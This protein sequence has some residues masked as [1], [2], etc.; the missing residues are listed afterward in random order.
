[1]SSEQK[2]LEGFDG[3]SSPETETREVRIGNMGDVVTGGTPSTK[4]EDNYGGDFPFMRVSDFNN[5]PFIQETGKKLTKKGR[6]EKKNKEIPEGA[7]MVSC[8]GTLGKTAFATEN[9]LTNQQV[10][11][12]VPAEDFDNWYVYYK[13]T[14]NR[15]LLQ[16]YAGGSAQPI[17][18]KSRF[19]DIE[20][21]VQPYESQKKIGEI[22]SRFDKKIRINNRINKI[23]EKMAQTVFKAWFVDFEQSESP[24]IIDSREGSKDFEYKPL[25]EIASFQNGKAW[26]DYTGEDNGLP[27]LKI[28]ELRDGI[29][30]NT[31][32][33]DRG[34]V[35]D[36]LIVS[37]GDI[38]FS[39]SATLLIDIWT[40]RDMFL[41]QHLFKVRSENYPKWFYYHW[42]KEHIQHFRHIA[43]SK[44]TT[45]GHIKRRDLDEAMCSVPERI[46]F[47]S[48]LGN[49]LDA[50]KILAEEN[51]KLES[52]RDT[53]LPKLMSGE[54]RV[55]T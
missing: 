9:C 22:L 10:N 1:M 17:L 33:V 7:V 11:S 20:L 36:F 25:S 34:K 41:N 32:Y 21:E 55:N 46:K 40:G 3:D 49:F 45:M 19:T 50:I 39:W 30:E 37:S 52:I 24:K 16:K 18:S 13:L 2:S 29:S 28:R 43:E 42:T 48:F 15:N 51:T 44:K 26:K 38:I 5:T 23:L 31:D 27:V 12:I 8:I 53:L 14:S 54:I 47:G 4:D 35:P 6:K